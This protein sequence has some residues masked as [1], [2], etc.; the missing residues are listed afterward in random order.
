MQSE[1]SVVTFEQNILRQIP[2]DR[3]LEGVFQS[4]QPDMLNALYGAPTVIIEGFALV[5]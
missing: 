1:F 4:R 3:S 2:T 5:P